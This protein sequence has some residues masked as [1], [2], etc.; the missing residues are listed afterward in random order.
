M[1]EV[2]NETASTNGL[3]TSFDAKSEQVVSMWG[4]GQNIMNIVKE[5]GLSLND[6][7]RIVVRFQAAQKE[8]SKESTSTEATSTEVEVDAEI[9][10]A[11]Q[12]YAAKE[13]DIEVKTEKAQPEK[14]ATV[15]T[16]TK[17]LEASAPKKRGRP[18]MTDAQKAAAKALRDGANASMK[19]KATAKVAK[20]A[21]AAPKAKAVKAVAKAAVA[22]AAPAVAPKKRGRPAK[23]KFAFAGPPV[24][25]PKT[26]GNGNGNGAHKNGAAPSH[27][28]AIIQLYEYSKKLGCSVESLVALAK[29]A[30]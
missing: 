6:V 10:A 17:K 5:T 20:A 1:T 26:N 25:G 29:S 24:A 3:S 4:S 11:E 9:A 12:E 18:K 30:T 28:E 22:K 15:K 8:G 2:V 27:Y 7:R 14:A 13:V 16:K 21:K 23:A 19:P